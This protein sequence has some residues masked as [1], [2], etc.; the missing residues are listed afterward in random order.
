MLEFRVV[1]RIYVLF[2]VFRRSTGSIVPQ[3]RHVG[4]SL[5]ANFNRTLVFCVQFIYYRVAFPVY[6]IFKPLV[7]F[8]SDFTQFINFFCALFRSRRS[9]ERFIL[10]VIIKKKHTIIFLIFSRPSFLRHRC[11][12]NRPKNRGIDYILN[13]ILFYVHRS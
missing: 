6:I 10:R 11:V 7:W 8:S 9:S 13:V 4:D 1:D 2:F 3:V 12:T 5:L